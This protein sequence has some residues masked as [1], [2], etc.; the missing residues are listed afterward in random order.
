VFQFYKRLIIK[1]R[2]SNTNQNLLDI[3]EKESYIIE[4]KAKFANLF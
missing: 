1:F 2:I 4:L 3:K